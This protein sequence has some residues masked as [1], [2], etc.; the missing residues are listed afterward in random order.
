MPA[1]APAIEPGN[2]GRNPTEKLT[3]SFC[4]PAAD[5]EERIG[6]PLDAKDRVIVPLRMF[7]EVERIHLLRQRELE[8]LIRAVPLR[9]SALRP[10]AR[11]PIQMYRIEPQALYTGQTFAL[12]SKLLSIMQ[13]LTHVM[14]GHLTHGL[15]K[16]P[17]AKVYGTTADGTKAM[18]WYV[19]PIL[20]EYSGVPVL[21]DGIHRSYICASAGTTIT[22]VHIRHVDCAMPYDSGPWSDV[23]VVQE[24]PSVAV[25]YRNLRRE[26]F[27]ELSHV[28]I[29]G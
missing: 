17:P 7:A 27:R 24:K 9:G 8:M 11:S 23:K 3:P 4:I 22:G 18:A 16:M 5:L 2:N 28:G 19:P 25:R 15:S 29:D 1:T 14:D 6:M 21:L 26:Y 13:G 12:A 20:E 10:Y